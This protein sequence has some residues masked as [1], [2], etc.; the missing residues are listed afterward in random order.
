MVP[1]R[2]GAATRRATP[3]LAAGQ[4]A[5]PASATTGGA[6][7]IPGG[8]LP[9]YLSLSAY[10]KIPSGQANSSE[11]GE[12]GERS[13]AQSFY[14]NAKV[15]GSVGGGMGVASCASMLNLVALSDLS[16][17]DRPAS[18]GMAPVMMS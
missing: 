13:A 14:A 15:A 9:S 16:D 4:T 18:I 3:R 12:G 1:H 2:I 10:G 11:H 5:Y 8:K 7:G 17:V 6:A